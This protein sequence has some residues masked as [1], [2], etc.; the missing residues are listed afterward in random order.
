MRLYDLEFNFIPELIEKFKRGEIQW[1][2]LLDIDLF[3]VQ[4]S[5]TENE[6]VWAD[7]F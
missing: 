2:D 6:F 1:N 4:N 5:D 7:I 3:K